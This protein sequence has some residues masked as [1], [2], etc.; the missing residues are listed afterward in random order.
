MSF[1]GRNS[2]RPPE[3]V[4]DAEQPTIRT[5]AAEQPTKHCPLF[6]G[7]LFATVQDYVGAIGRVAVGIFLHTL[8]C[9]VT[10]RVLRAVF[11]IYQ[12]LHPFEYWYLPI[13]DK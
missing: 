1:V 11:S 8:W 3:R 6:V 5:K 13:N 9:P 10:G 7:P 2:C 12:H 4:V